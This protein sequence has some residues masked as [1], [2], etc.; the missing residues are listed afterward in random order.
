MFHY[1]VGRPNLKLKI[2]IPE[3]TLPDS[4]E[5]DSLNSFGA[6]AF[7]ENSGPEPLASPESNSPR[8]FSWLTFPRSPPPVTSPSGTPPGS[9]VTPV[10]ERRFYALIPVTPPGGWEPLP[11]MRATPTGQPAAGISSTAAASVVS[12]APTDSP[13][14]DGS[15][16]TPPPSRN[17]IDRHPAAS[18]A[19]AKHGP[20]SKSRCYHCF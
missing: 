5:P 15:P 4:S 11:L 8:Y 16:V 18:P 12:V 6:S 1:N 10:E 13:R 20:F 3:T 14:L 19:R 17:W 2:A 9:P 7:L